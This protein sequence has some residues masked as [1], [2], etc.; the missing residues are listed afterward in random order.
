MNAKE[1]LNYNQCLE[2]AKLNYDGDYDF[3]YHATG[4]IWERGKKDKKERFL[5]APLRQQ[6]LR[7]FRDKYVLF[8]EIEVFIDDDDR[9]FFD[10]K[11]VDHPDKPKEYYDNDLYSTYEAAENDCIDKL[12]EL[13]KQQENG[14]T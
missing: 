12:I 7:W 11:I 4:E 1:F 2:L 10:F 14:N 3:I 8:L 9:L 6:V 5:P 13:A